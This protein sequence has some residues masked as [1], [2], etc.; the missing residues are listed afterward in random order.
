M[1]LECDDAMTPFVKH[2][3]GLEDGTHIASTVE[4]NRLPTEEQPKR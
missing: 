4:A 3:A 2:R 1:R